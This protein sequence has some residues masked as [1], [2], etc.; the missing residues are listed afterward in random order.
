MCL[1]TVCRKVSSNTP[2]T[3]YRNHAMPGILSCG[4]FLCLREDEIGTLI[5]MEMQSVI[6]VLSAAQR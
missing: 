3:V 5:G 1:V 6:N 4:A 2:I